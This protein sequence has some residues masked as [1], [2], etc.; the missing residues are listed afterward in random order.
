MAAYSKRRQG[1][2]E[3]GSCIDCGAKRTGKAVTRHRCRRCSAR[4]RK[5]T[6]AY[7]KRQT[8]AVREETKEKLRARH[9]ER[10]AERRA[11]GVC[12]RCGGEREVDSSYSTCAACLTALRRWS[13]WERMRRNG[14]PAGMEPVGCETAWPLGRAAP[15]LEGGKTWGVRL[16]ERTCEALRVLLAR[17]REQERAAGRVPKTHQVSRIVREVV[18]RW[19]RAACPPDRW[20]YRMFVMATVNVYLDARTRRI[21]EREAWERFGG[22]RSA[23]LRAMLTR[24]A[25]PIPVG[26][27]IRRRA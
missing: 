21:V 5:A 12:V 17:Y 23:A 16:D 25:L 8:E 15:R 3:A 9:R 26:A 4:C 19:E 1:W 18:L 20:P 22:N 27:V 7:R 6:R 13:A 10:R 14:A 24:A 11:A 2:L